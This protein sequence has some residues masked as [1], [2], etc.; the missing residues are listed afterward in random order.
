MVS[1]GKKKIDNF[2]G[3]YLPY[4]SPENSVR[5]HSIYPVRDTFDERKIH[6]INGVFA[7]PLGTS[8]PI[9]Y[10]THERTEQDYASQQDQAEKGKKQKKKSQIYG[11]G[12]NVVLHCFHHILTEKLQDSF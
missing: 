7:Y 1:S 12:P 11:I 2:A 9:S 10:R 4:T 8:H 6:H 5:A 3:S